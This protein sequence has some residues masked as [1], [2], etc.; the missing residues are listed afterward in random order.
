MPSVV[1]L[2]ARQLQTVRRGCARMH[3]KLLPANG[4]LHWVSTP[5]VVLQNLGKKDDKYAS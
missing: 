1:G 5:L 2:L 4:W 3:T